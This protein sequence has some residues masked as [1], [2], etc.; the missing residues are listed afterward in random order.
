VDQ[1]VV[2]QVTVTSITGGSTVPSGTVTVLAST[3]ENANCSL[4]SSAIALCTLTFSTN[5]VR[6]LTA[7][8]N[9]DTNFASSTSIPA[10]HTV[11]SLTPVVTIAGGYTN[12]TVVGTATSFDFTVTSSSGTPDG[13][14]E[15]ESNTGETCSGT[16]TNGSGSCSIVFTS[17]G[18]KTITAH[19]DGGAGDRYTAADSG[20]Y[21]ITVN[22][23]PTTLTITSD[24]P[25]STVVGETLT[26][27]FQVRSTTSTIIYPT[28][29]TVTVQTEGGGT[30]CTGSLGSTGTGSCSGAI[31]SVGDGTNTLT[32]TY[33]GSTSFQSS[34][35]TEDHTVAKADVTISVDSVS[36]T[37]TVVGEEV[38]I[39]AS[40][41]VDSPGSGTPTGTLVLTLSPDA[42][43][44]NSNDVEITAALSGGSATFTYAFPDIG[45][46][47]WKISYAGSANFNSDETSSA[48]QTV[49][50]GSVTISNI[51][52]A[53][54][55]MN[56]IDANIT[57]S[58][59]INITSPA[60]GGLDGQVRFT[61]LAGG[62]RPNRYC[63]DTAL[64]NFDGYAVAQCSIEASVRGD[65]S[66]QVAFSSDSNF[67]DRTYTTTASYEIIGID[68]T[69]EITTASISPASPS[70]FGTGVT[71]P[72][73]VT[74]DSEPQNLEDTDT[75]TVT[76]SKS[77]ASDIVVAATIS[78]GEAL[79]N[80]TETGTWQL[81]ARYN[82]GERHETSE[83]T[84]VTHIVRYPTSITFGETYS[85]P[86][87]VFLTT[88]TVYFTAQVD[89][90]NGIP[91][92]DVTV[93]AEKS[94]STPKACAVN[95]DET[96][97]GRCGIG[98]NSSDLGIWNITLEYQG[99]S[100][101]WAPSESD[102]LDTLEV[103]N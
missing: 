24:S 5:S 42:V 57:F 71:V 6:T 23:A 17:G 38:T 97:E 25:A 64:E 12:P 49:S 18:S 65:L 73:T 14:V 53:Y 77:G 43:F 95:L 63:D 52:P 33:A 22:A 11:N 10:S 101:T 34:S 78:A 36:D 13:S 75:V 94:G 8:Y 80:F 89:S 61:L 21:L 28:S 79:I 92:G 68:T 59:R 2:I 96:G 100:N 70:T 47:H 9:G 16:L 55:Y 93:W 51:T 54:P 99:T 3:G 39:Q 40:V 44:G 32:A 84:A 50:R 29:G 27:S 35:D 85:N 86:I 1:Q 83:S 58:A 69:T 7:T 74:P 37:T 19:Y 103:K 90:P 67:N 15:I 20:T 62:G 91:E 45:T 46:W 56:N 87:T 31:T 66:L 48:T 76:A 30:L 26:V 98:F 4:N 82:G 60:A 81:V 72:F 41:S 102:G 88:V